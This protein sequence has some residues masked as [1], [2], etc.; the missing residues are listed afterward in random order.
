MNIEKK[1]YFLKKK[2]KKYLRKKSKMCGGERTREFVGKCMREKKMIF[3]IFGNFQKFENEWWRIAEEIFSL[4]CD[5]PYTVSNKEL[6]TAHG[7]TVNNK[8]LFHN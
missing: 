4:L 1:N 2:K 8:K 3:F 7:P 5:N 6:F